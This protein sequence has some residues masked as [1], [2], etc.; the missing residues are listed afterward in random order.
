MVPRAPAAS[1]SLGP[2]ATTACRSLV[3]PVCWVH[4][5]RPA[6][7]LQRISPPLPAA[8]KHG[9]VPPTPQPVAVLVTLVRSDDE[10]DVWAVHVVPPLVVLRMVPPF[11]TAMPV[12]ASMKVTLLSTLV[13]PLVWATQSVAA[14]AGVTHARTGSK[15]ATMAAITS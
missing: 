2:R 11:P 13:V 10:P 1:T 9:P 8:Q 4:Q 14:A 12:L 15:A 5:V 3:V 6:S 7:L